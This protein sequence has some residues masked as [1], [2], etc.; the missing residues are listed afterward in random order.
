VSDGDPAVVT[1]PDNFA[2]VY[3]PRLGLTERTYPPPVADPE[4]TP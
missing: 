1:F 3:E 2:E 4:P